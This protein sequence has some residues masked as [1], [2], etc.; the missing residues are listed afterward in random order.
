MKKKLGLG[1]GV[2]LLTV[3]FIGCNNKVKKVEAENLIT[4][5]GQS[6]KYDIVNKKI[7]KNHVIGSVTN[8]SSEVSNTCFKINYWNIE[9]KNGMCSGY[10]QE[11]IRVT[12]IQPHKTVNYNVTVDG[13]DLSNKYYEVVK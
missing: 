3:G 10:Y 5:S 6:F 1:L 13:M 8:N 9:D 7:V 12:S 4:V 2:L 11:T